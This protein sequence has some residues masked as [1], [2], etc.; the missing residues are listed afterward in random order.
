LIVSE[1]VAFSK[2]DGVAVITVQNPPVNALS[3]GVPEGIVSALDQAE[4]DAG[5]QA[6]VLIGGGRTFIA[7]ADIRELEKAAAGD[8]RPPALHELLAKIEDSSKPVVMAIHGT[9]LGGGLEVAM[10]GHYRV[11]SPDAQMGQPE[12]NL[13]IIPGAEGTQ[14]LPRLVG[15]A[16]AVDLCVSGKPTK[17]SEALALGLIDRI[18]EGDLLAGAVEFSLEKTAAGGPHRK[19]R[20]RREKLGSADA[21]RPVFAAGREQARKTRRNMIA[22]L[23]AI[24]A[25][26][27]AAN[28][29]FEEGCRR[30]R[31]IIT[32]LLASDQCRALIHAFFAERAA[33]KIPGLPKDT[34]VLPI[35]NAAIIGAGTMGGG[36]AMALAN[37]GIP[38]RLKD[39]D[40]G[41]LERGMTA[42]RKN[43]ESSVKKGRFSQEVMDQRMALIRPQ[44]THEGFAEADL[45]IEAAFEKMALKKEIFAEFDGIAKPT[46]VLASNTST[47]DIDE[48]AA[49]TSRPHMV[50]GLHFFSPAHVMRL[51]EIVRGKATGNEVI[52]T[53]MALA[54][55]LRKVG[56]LVGNCWGFAG[57][58][59]MLPYMR[60]A[61]FLVEEG[62]TPEQVDRALY[63]WGMAMGI[64]AVDDLGGI[65]VQWHVRQE[66]K[67][68]E[69]TG[70]R[71]P[72]VLD[73]LY[74]MGRLGQKT[75]AG[76]YRYD[77]NRK[78]IPDPEVVA[79]IERTAKEAGIPRRT[80]GTEEIIERS[81]YSMINEGARILEEGH[82]LRASD[83]DTV[84]L[85]GYGFPAYRGGPMWYADTVGLEKVYRRIQEFHER[86]GAQWEPAP[87]LKRLAEQG[88]TFASL[89]AE[90]AREE[91]VTAV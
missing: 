25:L 31:E 20:E 35:R 62:A 2:V 10:A 42:I 29:P 23:R 3:P 76:W 64:F 81:I 12:V 30:E 52:A 77:E 58:R 48:I 5:V 79:L 61:Q 90:K 60:E 37:V 89:D 85:T 4:R 32:E 87:L 26:E 75:G 91:S 73:K 21:N 28:L 40:Q 34:P 68:L 44:L 78:P 18:V 13:G 11:A 33:S 43:Y 24:D 9:A 36:I 55:T 66:H 41:A 88:K 53:A 14:R 83:L 71:R 51:L 27:A 47:L 54:K 67:H 80:I 1:L 82:A 19:T 38:V 22:P 45:I 65:D 17:A 46:C 6:V 84:Y 16:A 86:F 39:V 72:L 49:S 56:V 59:M 8:G 7:G 57:N 50:I 74:R 63:E 69:P 15:I 70:L